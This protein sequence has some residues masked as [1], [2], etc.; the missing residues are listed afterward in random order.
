MNIKEDMEKE[1]FN[2]PLFKAGQF[3]YSSESL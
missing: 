1:G 3:I 2:A